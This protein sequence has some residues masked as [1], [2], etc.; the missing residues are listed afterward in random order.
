MIT[1]RDAAIH[2]GQSESEGEPTCA[3]T[4]WLSPP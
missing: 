4:S 1:E 2:V 3:F